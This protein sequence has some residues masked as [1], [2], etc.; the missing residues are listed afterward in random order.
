MRLVYNKTEFEEMLIKAA[1]V[2]PDRPVVISKFMENAMEIDFDGVACN[3]KVYAHAISQHIEAAGIHSGDSSLIQPAPDVDSDKRKQLFDI[4]EALTVALKVNGPFNLQFMYKNKQ[5]YVIEMNLRASRSFPFICK[6][7]GVNFMQLS[8]KVLLDSA[9]CKPI[10]CCPKKLGIKHF[11]VKCPKFSF[12]RLAGS[13]PILGLEMAST[14]EAGCLGRDPFEALLKS[15]LSTDIIIPESGDIFIV[16]E[17][18]N[19]LRNYSLFFAHMKKLGYTFSYFLSDSKGQKNEYEGLATKLEYEEACEMIENQKCKLAFSFA[20]PSPAIYLKTDQGELRKKLFTYKIPTILDP[21]LA[22]YFSQALVNGAH[23]NID[24]CKS[25]Q[26]YLGIVP[27][28]QNKQFV[29]HVIDEKVDILKSI[30]KNNNV[31]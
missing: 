11:G 13:D 25:L 30:M 19:S 22:Y 3:G 20:N 29:D 12:K 28:K 2:S 24:N 6:T 21:N 14:G 1:D 10:D 27:K 15:L 9:N 23:K 5:F 7:I 16:S 8:A 26:D 17:N 4:V 31:D 18:I